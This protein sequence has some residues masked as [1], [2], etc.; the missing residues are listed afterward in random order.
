[1]PKGNPNKQT[2][3]TEK[4]QRKAGYITKGF[5]I[6]KEVAEKFAE[7]CE[8]VGVSQ[9]GKITELMLEFAEKTKK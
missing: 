4:Y 8:T 9:A 7:A 2:Q 1:M 6:K 5:K 3:A